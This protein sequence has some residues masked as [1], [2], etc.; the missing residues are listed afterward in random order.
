MNAE[1]KQSLNFSEAHIKEFPQE[2]RDRLDDAWANTFIPLHEIKTHVIQEYEALESIRKALSELTIQFTK[3]D[4]E[5]S[6]R[7]NFTT[8]QGFQRVSDALTEFK[9]DLETLYFPHYQQLLGEISGKT[10]GASRQLPFQAFVFEALTHLKAFKV[11]KSEERLTEV[12]FAQEDDTRLKTEAEAFLDIIDRTS[13]ENR[14][15][16]AERLRSHFNR[17]KRFFCTQ[18]A[19]LRDFLNTK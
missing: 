14:K 17:G 4:D 7:L 18:G 19:S 12:I 10:E 9:S 1:Y 5:V 6:A 2:L 11:K 15:L 3:L 16:L 8:R 13:A